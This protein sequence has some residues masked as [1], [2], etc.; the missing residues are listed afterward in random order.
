MKVSGALWKKFYNDEEYWKEYYHDDTCILF[1]GVEQEDYDNPD[2]SATVVVES[3]YVYHSGD[4][5]INHDVTLE[6]FFKKWK[7]KQSVTYLVVEVD[8]E[9]AQSAKMI[10]GGV[11]GVKSVKGGK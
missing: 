2:D 4:E 7:S 1:D 8:K 3:G 9:H 5:K 6:K 10:I 11:V